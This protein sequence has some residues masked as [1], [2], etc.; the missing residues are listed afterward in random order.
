VNFRSVK[1]I[2][3]KELLDTVRDKRTLLMMIGVPVLLYPLLLIIG[4]Q[5]ALIQHATLDETVSRVALETTEPDLVRTWLDDVEMIEIV[6]SDSPN[7]DLD[8]GELDAVVYIAGPVAQPLAD[9]KS[10]EIEVRYDSTEFTSADASGRL[11]NGLDKDNNSLL[12]ARLVDANLDRSYIEPLSIERE[13]V[14][15]PAK[16]TGNALGSILPVM[17]VV[18]LALGAFYPAV[19]VT[20]GEKERGT[21]ETLLSTPTTKLEIVAG[22][23]MTVFLLA[24]A[25]GLLNLGSMAATFIFMANQLE[26]ILGGNVQFDIQIPPSAIVVFLFIMIPLAFFISAIM[27]AI[28]V[29]ARSFKE[30]QNYVTPFFIVITM[31]AVFASMPGVKL[32]AATQFIPIANVI[33]LFREMMTGKAGIETTFAV[34][35]STVAFAVIALQF[36]AWLFQR[37]EVVLSE[38]KGFP[39]TWRRNE[40]R[41]RPAITA[42]MALGLFTIMLI[43]LFFVGS[44]VQAWKLLPGLLITE[45]LML[46]APILF[47]LWYAKIDFRNALNL[48]PLTLSRTCA[49]IAVGFFSI[50]LVIQISF[51]FSQVLPVP[52]AMEEQ[53]AKLF[54]SDGS[55]TQLLALLFVAAFSPAICEEVMFRGAILSGMRTRLGFWPSA[56]IVGTLFGLFH[57]DVFRIPPIIVLGIIL[58]YLTLRTGSLYAAMIVH[59]MNNSFAILLT[60][61]HMPEFVG[62]VLAIE[63]FEEKGLP[64]PVL[65]VAL[66]GF[67]AS[68]TLLEWIATESKDPGEDTDADTP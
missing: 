33:L 19:D 35:L 59:F 65:G 3:K 43:M 16:T 42:S 52:E 8:A 4:L 26:P 18:M 28:A 57:M 47:L 5:G 46:L 27:M 50:I 40:F 31:P 58:T 49:S 7:E 67:I 55:I 38:E 68:I 13:D 10:I 17:M 1:T 48:R 25:T 24:M 66:I 61:G 2:F 6:E 56:I 34:F 45:W 30:A 20:A 32:S 21:F 62:T 23:F 64:L 53:M 11:R 15:P 9:G 12:D 14:A 39:L 44:T 60:T 41:P 51:W 29:F 36:A 54:A 63:T 22:K 37:E